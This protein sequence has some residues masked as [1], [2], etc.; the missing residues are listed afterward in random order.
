M[1]RFPN[2]SILNLLTTDT[3]NQNCFNV[4][5]LAAIAQPDFFE[6]RTPYWYPNRG[7]NGNA[8]LVCV[9]DKVRQWFACGTDMQIDTL[10]NKIIMTAKIDIDG[11]SIEFRLPLFK[12]DNHASNSYSGRNQNEMEVYKVSNNLHLPRRL[13]ENENCKI[14][15]GFAPE[16]SDIKHLF[17]VGLY[18]K[19]ALI[20]K[21][22]E[23][24][25]AYNERRK[26]YL[27]F[28]GVNP[29]EDKSNDTREMIGFYQADY[30]QV[31]QYEGRFYDKDNNEVGKGVIN[32]KNGVFQTP[33][34]DPSGTGSVKIYKNGEIAKEVD[35]TLIKDIQFDMN[36]ASATLIDAYGRQIM[37]TEKKEERPTSIESYTFQREAFS[38]PRDAN[39]RLSDKFVEILK[40]LGPRIVIADPYYFNYI[41][42]NK[43]TKLL[44]TTA[45]QE[46][47]LNA[48]VTVAITTDTESLSFLGCSRANSHSN[49]DPTLG[50]TTREQRFERYEKLFTT[51]VSNNK[52][53]KYMSTGQIR[54][55][56]ASKNFHNRYWFG[57]AEN[58]K[59][60]S[61]IVAVTNSLGIMEEVD[62][63]SVTDTNQADVI[64]HKFFQ[65]YNTA[66]NDLYI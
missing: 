5:L 51:I 55:L 62:F 27:T 57:L 15:S 65:L 21:F 23:C 9:N 34:T 7:K 31:A 22:E 66:S 10:F 14:L 44:E 59:S 20:G 38:A 24:V 36:P 63:F 28:H 53:N 45:C 12:K 1:R 47:F 41:K 42:E 6:N 48:I 49:K 50:T 19:N 56:T 11:K 4:V 2:A 25:F 40:F 35:Y 58:C 29:Q 60:F 33:V 46:A 17:P 54:F 39:I 32:K 43:D 61:R 64:S 18:D 52:L 37:I 30:E 13:L 26:P 16:N 3:A 8:K